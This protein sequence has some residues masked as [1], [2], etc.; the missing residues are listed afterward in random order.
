MT[1]TH[2]ECTLEADGGDPAARATDWQSMVA[3][4]TTR[5]RIDNGVAV[6][7]T[8]DVERTAR[9]ARLMAAE[10][11]CCS[12]ATYQLTIDSNGVRMEIHTPP[13]ARGMFD[14]LVDV[15]T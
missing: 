4:A 13:Q 12:F 14:P 10:Y 6:T 11:A 5:E 9:L 1:E 8:H 7:F 2:I 15:G 3:G